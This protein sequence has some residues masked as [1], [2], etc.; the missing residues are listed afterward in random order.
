MFVVLQ[1]FH[2]F[3]YKFENCS[4]LTT[5]LDFQLEFCITPLQLQETESE[6]VG[7]SLKPQREV[8]GRS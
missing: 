5:N 1:L 6:D 7:K 4:D 3:K 8:V 2:G